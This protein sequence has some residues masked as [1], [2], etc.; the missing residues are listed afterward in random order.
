METNEVLTVSEAARLK[1]T[2]RQAVRDAVKAGKIRASVSGGYAIL[3]D[4][5]SV[6]DWQPSSR[7]GTR[8]GKFRQPRRVRRLH[9]G[10][11]PISRTTLPAPVSQG[12]WFAIKPGVWIG[13][14]L[15][16]EFQESE[17]PANAVP[18]FRNDE[19]I[20]IRYSTK[21]KATNA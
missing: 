6:E 13:L 8:I 16:E 18:V 14:V 2:S 10:F 12:R 17:L 19:F 5:R 11:V 7:A 20:V 1:G 9:A 15:S 21:R 3:L 4:R